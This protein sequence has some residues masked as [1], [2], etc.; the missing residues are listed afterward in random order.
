MRNFFHFHSFPF[1]PHSSVQPLSLLCSSAV[2][3]ITPACC[4]LLFS[5]SVLT[6]AKHFRAGFMWAELLSHK[7]STAPSLRQST[8][9]VA[10][11]VLIPCGSM[12]SRRLQILPASTSSVF[13]CWV[14]M[15]SF[16]W[17]KLSSRST[18]T[19]PS[20]LVCFRVIYLQV[21][22]NDGLS[23]ISSNVHITTTECVSGSFFAR[24]SLL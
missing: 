5:H 15:A 13:L 8:H 10:D 2:H 16:W 23:F 3:T 21:S 7:W 14:P 17:N 22:M 18:K 20:L 19:Y 24:G 1:S 9:P 4:C 11:S 12:L 6:T